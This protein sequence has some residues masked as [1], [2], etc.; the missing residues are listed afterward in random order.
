M[1]IPLVGGR[2]APLAGPFAL[3]L[4]TGERVYLAIEPCRDEIEQRAWAERRAALCGLWHPRLA[5]C[6][7]F[8]PLGTGHRLTAYRASRRAGAGDMRAWT[9]ARLQVEA[10]LAA[11][12]IDSGTAAAP[13]EDARDRLVV[14][15]EVDAAAPPCGGSSSVE[16]Q[17]SRRAGP[18]PSSGAWFGIRLANRPVLHTVIEHLTL[19]APP[20]IAIV[21]I[22]AAFDS[23]GRTL[24]RACAR[25]ARRHGYVP[26]STAA[27]AW[28][29]A[30]GEPAV[31]GWTATLG[32]HHLAVLHDG[33]RRPFRQAADAW[34][35]LLRM[36][37]REPRT[38]VVL[39]LTKPGGSPRFRLQPL[40]DRELI[41]M[42]VLPASAAGLRARIEHA[43]RACRGRPGRFVRSLARLAARGGG[44]GRTRPPYTVHEERASYGDDDEPPCV[45]VPGR[46]RREL[47]ARITDGGGVD[48]EADRGAGPLTAAAQR[49]AVRGRH[50]AADRSLRR[51]H[52]M[53]SRRAHWAAAAD[54]AIVRARLRAAR[55][56]TEQAER[57]LIDALEC[58][59]RA[60]AAARAVVTL[61]ELGLLQLEDARVE[62]AES[63]LRSALSAVSRVEDPVLECWIAGSLALCLWWQGRHEEGLRVLGEREPPAGDPPAD[64]PW[65][66]GSWLSARTVFAAW[67]CTAA[68]HAVS[69]GET[70]S[71]RRQLDRAEAVSRDAD[72]STVAMVCRTAARW[73]A[74]VGDAAGF[75]AAATGA[76]RHAVGA[77][78]PLD[79][80][81]AMA[82]H[83]EG[84]RRL[85]E[86]PQRCRA[87]VR[88]L[89]LAARRRLP[90]LLALRIRLAAGLWRGT[91]TP[92]RAAVDCRARRLDALVPVRAA[93]PLPS[94]SGPQARSGMYEDVIEVLGICQEEEPA[95]ALA[96]V[97]EI[98]G[99]RTRAAAAGFVSA[100]GALDLTR[101]RGVRPPSIATRVIETGLPIEPVATERGTEAGVPLRFA[102]RVIGALTCRW[103]GELPLERPALMGLLAAVAAAGAPPLQA[104][105]DQRRPADPRPAGE[106]ELLGE[107]AA[108]DE[109]R[110]AAVRA[111]DA[112]FP[113]LI[114]GESGSGKELVA[115]A[116]H[117]AGA[118]RGRSFC[119][120][121][122]AALPDDLLEAELFG[123]ARGAFTGA[124]AERAGLFEDADGGVLFLDEVGELTPRGQA[125]LLRAIQEGEIKRLGET[126]ARKVDVRII[127]ATNRPLEQEVAAGRFRRDLRYR[128]DVI[129]IAIPP[130]RD[131]P[132]DIPLLAQH[133]WRSAAARVGCR[134]VLSG[135]VLAALARHD[136]PG[137]VRELQ[138][139]L[140]ALAVTAPR[141]GIVG[142]AALPATLAS[143]AVRGSATTLEEARRVFE[144]RYV[145]AAL[146]R[147]GGHRG[148]AAAELGVTRQGLAKLMGRLGVNPA[149][150]SAPAAPAPR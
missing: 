76:A 19:D 82:G 9:G 54:A 14:L 110:R 107:S 45:R 26:V 68:R 120:L 29:A 42:I 74:A 55:G 35:P 27:L 84:A 112:P 123:H 10:F 85:Q 141:R 5:E 66:A 102:G 83:V 18:Q 40:T 51:V 4:A 33:R 31:A 143:A 43:A 44:T 24:L 2:F 125:K 8:G 88:R 94:I 36:G 58:A 124:V 37:M 12:G 101:P 103:L 80:L 148:R 117:R 113:V 23:G 1:E 32:R 78:Q 81:R 126:F 98:V 144:E 67:H 73:H 93:D 150:E 97:L 63:S 72:A 20:G 52:A 71:A 15:P 145:R 116:I 122:C 146:A 114:Q 59:E 128:L 60:H 115:R 53:A 121:N 91:I 7:D 79:R 96:R 75:H 28:M 22:E 99:R 95:G 137:N 70:A 34:G 109:I 30:Q 69:L 77:H 41:E 129:R 65:A 49:L 108:M 25:E 106:F 142:T 38:R 16:A 127:A 6:L 13:F 11:C 61:T 147:S 50:A 134:A 39:E 149:V 105:L 138:N 17:G 64:G 21:V 57:L 135:G 86:D 118:R 139:V 136:W 90:G 119:A 104:A 46:W 87:I 133:L 89:E 62:G 100:D 92:D 47:A 140:A 3:D 56:G 111:A 132:D 130:L 131:R 48:A